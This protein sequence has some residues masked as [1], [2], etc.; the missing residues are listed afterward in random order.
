MSKLATPETIQQILSCYSALGNKKLKI[1]NSFEYYDCPLWRNS[2]MTPI[3][4]S[5]QAS[6]DKEITKIETM[7]KKPILKSRF[8]SQTPYFNLLTQ[9]K[10]PLDKK[11]I[12]KLDSLGWVTT[13]RENSLNLWT[14]LID[15]KIPKGVQV[16]FGNYFDPQIYPH[17]LK[18]MEE[19]FSCNEI[20]MK[21][22]NKMLRTCEEDVM[23]ILLCKNDKTLGAGLVA[24]KNG[25]AY[26][27]CGSINKAYRNKKLWK[28][29]AAARQAASAARGA[30]VW[31]T[32]TNTPQLLWRGDETYRISVFTKKQA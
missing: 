14:N 5:K 9:G 18:T 30:K 29:L 26:L 2:A 20:F 1:G 22:L 28:V 8:S 12:F 13:P 23:T 19:N 11:L 10:S 17:F 4:I 27:F 31:V 16:K 24:V 7:F 32:T 21:S 25:G 15:L 6:W 3:L